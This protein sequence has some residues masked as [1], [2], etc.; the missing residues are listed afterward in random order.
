MVTDAPGCQVCLKIK[1][2]SGA[3]RFS[4]SANLSILA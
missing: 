1:V 2:G 3:R 4:S